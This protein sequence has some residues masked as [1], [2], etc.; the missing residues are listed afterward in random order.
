[1]PFI[2]PIEILDLQH[3][4]IASIDGYL[5]KKTK[6]KLFVEIELSDNGRF[7]YKGHKLLKSDCERVIEE[8]NEKRKKEYYYQLATVLQPLNNYLVDGNKLFLSHF[9]H[10]SIYQLADFKDF[11]NPTFAQNFDRSLFKAFKNADQRLFSSVLRTRSLINPSNINTAFKSVGL[12]I[13]NR[14]A[15]IDK[16]TDEIKTKKSDYATWLLGEALDIVKKKFQINMLNL[17]PEYFQSQI[18]KI[19][20]SINFLALAIDKYCNNTQLPEDLLSHILKL[21]IT[22]VGKQTFE[23]NFR[24]FKEIN[25]EKIEQ[26]KNAPLRK[27]WADTL[28]QITNSI[29]QVDEK[30]LTANEAATYADVA[31]SVSELNSLP[32]FANE[33]RNQIGYALRDLSI[34]C[35]NSQKD[36]NAA[37]KL[38]RQSLIINVSQAAR[39]KL[40]MDLKDLEDIKEKMLVGQLSTQ[41][42]STDKLGLYVLIALVALFLIAIIIRSA[43]SSNGST[44]PVENYTNNSSMLPTTNDPSTNTSNS[45]DVNTTQSPNTITT[46]DNNYPKKSVPTYQIINVKNGAFMDCA[47]IKPIYDYKIKNKLVITAENTDAAVKIVNYKSNKCIRFV[48]INNGTTYTVRNI[49]EGKY[50]LKI[51]YGDNWE[52]KDGDPLCTG[53]FAY[54]ALYK[55]DE[56]VYDFNKIHYED[57]RISIPYFTLRLFT[58]YTSNK[59]ENLTQANTISENDFSNDN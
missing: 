22:S 43:N 17:L 41:N 12:D 46:D 24:I 7:N 20:S 51:A 29:R 3:A 58:R 13:Q 5:I 30:T 8:L 33:I 48:F 23:N 36:M 18:N 9:K 21:N 25:A 57:G 40:E 28:F 50:F 1:M 55:K 2:N 52:I 42:E 11:I 10:E 6:R 39:Q 14:I 35:W 27:K 59:Y 38:V 16:I 49:P 56:D 47:N 19:A 31:V 15:E 54:N 53:R 26:E 32:S 34:S 44:A 45:T 4:D 37:L